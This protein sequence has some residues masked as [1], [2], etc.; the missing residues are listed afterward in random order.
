V[1]FRPVPVTPLSARTGGSVSKPLL[2]WIDC[3]VG[4][5]DAA[6]RV[7]AATVFE[8]M[9]VRGT[10]AAAAELARGR[11][12]ALCF[13]FDYPDQ[14]SLRAMQLIKQSHPRLPILM[15]TLEHT[16]SLAIWAFRA[17]VWNYL[18]KPILPVE[19]TDNLRALANLGSRTSPPRLAQLPKAEMPSDLPA[20]SLAPD[21][22]RLQPALD[23]VARN[24]HGRVTASAAGLCCG[25][26][27]FDFSR[28]FHAAFGR[29]FRDYLL[30]V[31]IA[32]ACRLLNEGRVSVTGAAYS[33]G[34][35][36]GSHFARMFKR[37]TG[38]LPSEYQGAVETPPAS[39][40]VADTAY[41]GMRRRS[42]DCLSVATTPL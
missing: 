36:D 7:R 27:R 14:D 20:Q 24:Y 18:V 25:L 38:V 19:L 32:E 37:F 39:S 40:A 10:G 28:K 5:P 6:P 12:Q 21:V 13:D 33:V 31:R 15:L 26:K 3:T 42:S 35:N 41:S 16:E 30:R 4:L 22:A 29:T 23:Y 8:V 17:R 1:R 9:H 34:F 2:L 11:P